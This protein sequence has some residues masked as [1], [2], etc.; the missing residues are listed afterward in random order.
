MH[1]TFYFCAIA[2][3]ALIIL[4]FLATLVGFGGSDLDADG[5]LDADVG[6]SDGGFDFIKALGVRTLT[7]GV[8]FWGFGGLIAESSG[9]G[10]LASLAVAVCCGIA[11]IVVVFYLLRAASSFNQNGAIRVDS[12]VNSTGSVYLR[13]PA[14]R[15]G[16]GKVIVTQQERSIEY[17]ALTDEEDDLTAGTPIVVVAVL[18]SS[19]VLVA[20]TKNAEPTS[21]SK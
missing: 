15:G 13:I 10:T 18:S 14:R 12:T 3:S 8:A 5:N 6:G 16:I 19:Q 4:Q 2:G 9:L 11:A 1:N 20:K 7:A 17:D 21:F